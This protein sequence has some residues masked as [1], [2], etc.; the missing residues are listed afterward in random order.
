MLRLRVLCSSRTCAH[1][2]GDGR[3][4]VCQHPTSKQLIPYGGITKMYVDE[5]DLHERTKH[6]KG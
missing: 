3:Y 1:R 6:M 5:C 2:C 4:G